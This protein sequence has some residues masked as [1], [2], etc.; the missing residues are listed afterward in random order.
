MN[1]RAAGGGESIE[2]GDAGFDVRFFT[3]SRRETYAVWQNASREVAF[4]DAPVVRPFVSRP[5]K[6]VAPGWWWSST[7]GR[8]VHFGSAAMRTQVM[9]ADQDP[10]VHALACRPLELRWQED[11][12]VRTHAPQLMLRLRDGGGVLADCT[13]R[14]EPSARQRWLARVVGWACAGVG[15][16]YWLLGPVERVYRL[17]VTWLSRYRHPRCHG[18]MERARAL[19]A[20]F[21]GG[22]PLVEGAAEV[23]D[24]IGVLPA[25][26][27]AL[28]S[29]V[30]AADLSV[31]LHERTQVTAVASVQE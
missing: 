14:G 26:F 16:Q 10:R 31:P 21:C 11:G 8:L 1:M 4:E 2:P 9:L 28:W 12:R 19:Q 29:G 23:G 7:T 5:G 13:V 3:P 18:G 22:R 17:N 30:L 20:V 24:P 27:H 6:R 15:W 25:V